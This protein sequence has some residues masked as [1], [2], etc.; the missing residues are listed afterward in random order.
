[1]DKKRV[2]GSWKNKIVA[3]ELVEER[4]NNN[5]DQE[6]LKNIFLDNPKAQEISLKART[7]LLEDSNLRPSH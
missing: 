3:T 2:H 7:D 4:A 1:M 5:C 6:E